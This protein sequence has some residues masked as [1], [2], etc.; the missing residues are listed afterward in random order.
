[1]VALSADAHLNTCY[2]HFLYFVLE[3]DLVEPKELAPLEEL[4][5]EL[6]GGALRGGGGGGGTVSTQPGGQAGLVGPA[7]GGMVPQI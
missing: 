5:N 4:S 3:F 2:R 7:G 1:M 6:T